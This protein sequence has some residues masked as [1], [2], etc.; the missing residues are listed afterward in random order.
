MIDANGKSNSSIEAVP[1][2][3]A[4]RPAENGRN[5]KR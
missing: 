1:F 3:Y 5:T 2:S 4:K